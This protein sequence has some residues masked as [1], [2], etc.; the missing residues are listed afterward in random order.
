MLIKDFTEK[1]TAEYSTILTDK[2]PTSAWP[3]LPGTPLPLNAIVALT[4]VSLHDGEECV[5]DDHPPVII[6]GRQ[7]IALITLGVVQPA[8]NGLFATY[9]DGPLDHPNDM[10]PVK[11]LFVTFP[12]ACQAFR[13]SSRK[14]ELHIATFHLMHTTGERYWQ[15]GMRIENLGG[16]S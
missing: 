4:L 9:Q 13:V 8:T 3:T 7:N 10:T 11:T 6:N 1:S 14:R 2:R 16:V 12:P 15:V 5:D